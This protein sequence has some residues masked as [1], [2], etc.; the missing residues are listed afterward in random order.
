MTTVMISKSL[1]KVMDVLQHTK[2][3]TIVHVKA[4]QIVEMTETTANEVN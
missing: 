1:K 4:A 3:V 2:S